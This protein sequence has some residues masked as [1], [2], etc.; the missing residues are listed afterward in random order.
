MLYKEDFDI[1]REPNC[2]QCSL[3]ANCKTICLMG[4]G[5]YNAEIMLIGEA[6]GENEDIK[7]E[8]FVGDAGKLLNA[9]LREFKLP[10]EEL[11]ITN[12]VKCR[13]PQNRKPKNTELIACRPYILDEISLLKPKI[14]I[15]L[16]A[17]AMQ[18]LL[19]LKKPF[20]ISSNRG[21]VF[22][23]NDRDLKHIPII[24]TYHPAAIR[25]NEEL[26]SPC[27]QDFETAL[28]ILREGYTPPRPSKYYAGVAEVK[29]YCV[30]D[31]ETNQLSPFIEGP[32]I[33]CIG[34]ST[35]DREGYCTDV[36][37][38]PDIRKVLADPTITKI[39]HNIKFDYKWLRKFKF[40]IKGPLY[41][42][43]V[44]AHILNENRPSLGLKELAIEY[45]DMGRYDENHERALKL[46]KGDR[47]KIPSKLRNMYCAQDCDATHRL[48]TLFDPQIKEEGLQNVFD[49]TMQGVK[50][51]ANAE[52]LGFNID[53]DRWALL[54]AIFAR[55]INNILAK[56]RLET[57]EAEF[58][59][60]SI[61][62]LTKI[63]VGKL[64]LPIVGYTIKG[65]ISSD[66]ASLNKMKE[67]D[68]SGIV[69]TILLYR[70]LTGD[71]SK[72]LNLDDPPFYPDGRIHAEFN[73]CGADTGRWSCNNPNLQAVTKD[74]P[75][76]SM[77]ISNFKNGKLMQVDYDQGEL[78]ILAQESK[79]KRL[80]EI[81][82]SGKDIHTA[83]A[84]E[85]L[86]IPEEDV[87][88]AQRFEAKTINFGIIYGLGAE[89]LA[90]KANMP[91]GKAIKYIREYKSRLI[92][93]REYMERKETEIM[94]EGEVI[95]LFGG[96]RRITI[97]DAH[98]HK[99][100]SSAKRKAINSPIQGGLHHLNILSMVRSS[101][102]MIRRGFRSRVLAPIHD[103]V[104]FDVY[105]KE[106]EELKILLKEVF[107]QPDTSK[108][109]FEF[110]VPLTVSIKSGINWKE[111]Q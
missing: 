45:T 40:P 110:V 57:G 9:I 67:Y 102:E 48:Y 24:P 107:T 10:R 50:V 78:R 85:L 13:P 64:G 53:Q 35:K 88:E 75:I 104:V 91:V 4:S 12:V 58:N 56:L 93:V 86:N 19:E 79:D 97:I 108:F 94:E 83:T 89:K 11:Y 72:Y 73:V 33:Y 100:V 8:P 84:A 2:S 82:A 26:L 70:K 101:K 71:Y 43:R 69:E 54:S 30:I 65:A 62:Q 74:S 59:P 23:L 87:T 5:N 98:D 34:T 68:T 111:I 38:E 27:L 7:Q 31:I 60:R 32:E 18:S 66:L 77:F 55:D 37:D 81:F 92:G 25:R 17:T 76:R 41:D 15:T 28:N 90:I 21:T 29:N 99:I 103:A 96:K 51:I 44:A 6:P 20:T 46:L 42:T 109:G 3:S 16:G 61:Q 106:E 49:L 63:L 95:N 39:G 52:L 105:P 80:L 14:I 36:I 1:I 22:F 47:S